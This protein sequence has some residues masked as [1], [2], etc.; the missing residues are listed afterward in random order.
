MK[1]LFLL[2]L[3]IVALGFQG[4]AQE[5]AKNAIGLRIGDSDGFGPEI[6]YQRGL[7]DNNRWSRS[8]NWN[9]ELR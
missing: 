5:I 9:S 3:T 7:G 4:S 8:W 6:N 1:K 2:I